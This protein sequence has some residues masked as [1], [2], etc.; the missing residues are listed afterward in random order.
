MSKENLSKK[1]MKKSP[2]LTLYM[3]LLV[4]WS[5]AVNLVAPSTLPDAERRHFEDSL[6]LLP[7]IPEDAKILFD[8]GSGAGFPGLVLAMERPDIGVHLFESDQ[9]KCA[10]LS[11]VSR[12]TDTPVLIHNQRIEN[13]DENST[14]L[15]DVITARALASLDQ[16]LGLTEQWWSRNPQAILVFPKGEKAVAEVED[17]RK[18]YDFDLESVPSVT[19]GRAQILRLSHV[20]K[21]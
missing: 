20:K 21:K 19:D 15:P 7:L 5:K 3:A 6:Q 1:P 11:T 4:K 9:K 2:K 14:L 8:L 12:E 13:V 10:F 18:K 16:L 17:A